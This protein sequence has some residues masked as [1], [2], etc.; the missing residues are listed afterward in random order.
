M[1]VTS[2]NQMMQYQENTVDE[3]E[4]LISGSSVFVTS[5]FKTCGLDHYQGNTLAC[6]LT[7]KDVS[8]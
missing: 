8:L 4:H 5:F 7:K 3:L 2:D 6:V 1:T